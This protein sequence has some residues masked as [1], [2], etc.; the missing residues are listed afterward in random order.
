MGTDKKRNREERLKGGGGGGKIVAELSR[1][2]R[3][4]EHHG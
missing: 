1:A 3:A 2:Q 4:A